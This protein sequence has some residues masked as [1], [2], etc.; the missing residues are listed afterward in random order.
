MDLVAGIPP[1][2][3]QQEGHLS[4]KCKQ[5]KKEKG[6]KRAKEKS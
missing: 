6:E 4:R 2:E 1:G 3:D 5:R